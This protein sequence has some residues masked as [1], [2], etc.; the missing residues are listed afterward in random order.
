MRK[1]FNRE[2]L[3]Y[4]LCGLLAIL[5][6]YLVFWLALC[7][8]GE[9]RVLFVN[10]IA[11]V[12]AT[13]FAFFTNKHLVFRTG[14]AGLKAALRELAMFFAARIASFG[15]E[16]AGLWLATSVLHVERYTLFGFGGILIAKVLLLCISA[17]MNYILSKFVI[18]KK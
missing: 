13:T 14:G 17:L 16:E 2:L 1:I 7:L 8:L 6:N 5:V 18:F 3:I 9:S 10:V 4:F 11:F 12:V 15:V